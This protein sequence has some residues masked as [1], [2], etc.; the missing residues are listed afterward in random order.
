MNGLPDTQEEE[1]KACLPAKLLA[2]SSLLSLQN[3]TITS[4]LRA[5]HEAYQARPFKNLSHTL[6]S[7]EM[8]SITEPARESMCLVEGVLVQHQFTHSLAK[9]LAFH[10]VHSFIHWLVLGQPAPLSRSRFLAFRPLAHQYESPRSSLCC[11]THL[12]GSADNLDRGC[13]PP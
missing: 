8:R 7:W 4:R 5:S 1:H 13:R 6:S 11:S 12:C 2:T 3:K 10:L 9:T